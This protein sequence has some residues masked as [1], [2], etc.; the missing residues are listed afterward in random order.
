MD[1]SGRGQW[2]CKLQ[3]QLRQMQ[4]FH[5]LGVKIQ[6][7]KRLKINN[8]VNIVNN[9]LSS[10]IKLQIE[11]EIS[12]RACEV[13]CRW[14][15]LKRVLLAQLASWSSAS[16]VMNWL[17][18]ATNDGSMQEGTSLRSKMFSVSS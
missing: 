1:F 12:T 2:L 15:L 4:L 13:S 8:Y 18:T 10:I 9:Q 16:D 3:H 7:R 14:C 11:N 17:Q 6:L 5:N